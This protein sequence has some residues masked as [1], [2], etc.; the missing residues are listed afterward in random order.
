MLE[1]KKKEQIRRMSTEGQ[2]TSQIARKLGVDPK[3]VRKYAGPRNEGQNSNVSLPKA[4]AGSDETKIRGERAALLFDL[5]NH[6]VKPEDAVVKAKEPPDVV[7]EM[8]EKWIELKESGTFTIE[9]REG[10]ELRK[11]ISAS[12]VALIKRLDELEIMVGRIRT[13]LQR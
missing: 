2:S 1:E 8:F 12:E 10:A 6:G 3:T 5:F 11:R 7:L 13:T 9:S 4:F